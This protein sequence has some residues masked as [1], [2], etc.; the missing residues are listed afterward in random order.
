MVIDL[1]SCQITLMCSEKHSSELCMYTCTGKVSSP[2]WVLVASYIHVFLCTGMYLQ[3]MC[4]YDYI[5][6]VTTLNLLSS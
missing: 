5:Y 1:T 4:V 2:G 3:C 6:S